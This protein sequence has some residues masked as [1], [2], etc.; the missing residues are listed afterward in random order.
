M[1]KIHLSSWENK[2]IP[3]MIFKIW[4]AGRLLVI[5]SREEVIQWN[6]NGDLEVGG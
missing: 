2:I 4:R 3:A 6:G 1:L 5:G